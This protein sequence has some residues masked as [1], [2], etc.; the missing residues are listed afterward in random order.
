MEYSGPDARGLT[1][2]QT[3]SIGLLCFGEIRGSPYCPNLSS[4][5][6]IFEYVKDLFLGI[7][8]QKCSAP[9]V[10]FVILMA[11]RSS[12]NMAVLTVRAKFVRILSDTVKC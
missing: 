8:L 5:K 4:V 3:Y 6:R 9:A 1:L 7:T 11:Q 12:A 2:T 10:K